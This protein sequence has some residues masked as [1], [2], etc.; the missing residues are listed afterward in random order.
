MIKFGIP[1]RKSNG[2]HFNDLFCGA[3]GLSIGFEEAGFHPSI[4]IDN[5][6]QCVETYNFNHTNAPI[7]AQIDLASADAI[8]KIPLAPLTIGG[9]PCQ[10]FSNANRQRSPFDQRNKLYVSFLN[11]AEA[12]KSDF[13][14]IEN[15]P[16]ILRISEEVTKELKSR[17]FTA[18]PYLLEASKFGAPQKRKR[19]F[20]IGIRNYPQP[21]RDNFFR[22]LEA[23]LLSHEASTPTLLKH[24]ISDLPQLKAK[25]VR[26]ATPL[27]NE[28]FGYTVDTNR[29]KRLTVYSSNVSLGFNNPF[30]YNHRTKYNNERDIEIYAT[31]QP[32][33]DSLSK[34]IAH[35]NPYK[36]RDHIFK[37]KFYKL[38]YES[39][40]KTI[41]AHMYYDCHMYI[42]PKQARGLTPREAARIQGFPDSY[43]FTG[44]PN[45][46]YRQIGN[47]VSPLVA[48]AV[49]KSV[50]S[51]I[52]SL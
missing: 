4:A 7:A 22:I 12:A 51:A 43:I 13:I 18:K 29:N 3:G 48:R 42:H 21:A 26:N 34:S 16:G 41:T 11:A 14:V 40:C 24:A 46:W 36:N 19:V 27:E 44:K 50:L 47:A 25:T 23:T 30:V 15:V 49:A 31:L 35:I 28:Q 6:A 2:I 33:E 10:G 39:L 20:W 17:G 5:N 45:E 38:K 37:D 52:K 32:G 8:S 1:S 9:P